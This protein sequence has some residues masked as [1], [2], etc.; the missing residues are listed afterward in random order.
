MPTPALS[1]HTQDLRP[2]PAPA[3]EPGRAGAGFANLLSLQLQAPS[4]A[5]PGLERHAE[6]PRPTV[7]RET[8]RR[9]PTPSASNA[10]STPATRP[11]EP[12]RAQERDTPRTEREP[13]T[14]LSPEPQRAAEPSAALRKPKTAAKPSGG[15]GAGAGDAKAGAPSGS[16]PPTAPATDTTASAAEGT[17]KPAAAE[18]EPAGADAASVQEAI[19]ALLAAPQ[20]ESA[21]ETTEDTAASPPEQASNPGQTQV[22]HSLAESVAPQVRPAEEQ[23]AEGPEAV[24]PAA[25]AATSVRAALH[26]AASPPVTGAPAAA[27]ESPPGAKPAAGDK[28]AP[29][30]ELPIKTERNGEQEA[31]PLELSNAT[32]ALTPATPDTPPT[33]PETPPLAHSAAAAVQPEASAAAAAAGLHHP[34]AAEAQA[35]R[36]EPGVQVLPPLAGSAPASGPALPLSGG[37]PV[38]SAYMR[39]APGQAGFAQELGAQVAVW[40]REGVQQAQLNLNPAELGPVQVRILLDGQQ[41]QVQFVVEH[42][43]TREA[44][45]AGVAE[46]NQALK[47]EGLSLGRA[48]VHTGSGRDSAQGAAAQGQDGRGDGRPRS[49]SPWAGEPSSPNTPQPR[50]PASRGLLDLYA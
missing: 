25:T 43:Q 2:Q 21:P 16:A 32:S 29:G 7:E 23:A 10:P 22:A 18:E 44:L 8:A 6:L 34:A 30:A 36:S 48:D 14:E 19:A 15:A 31:A 39:H 20:Q 17:A 40:V 26:A 1:L 47:S 37:S 12:A 13:S 28:M 42:S 24:R 38:G 49:A 41:A 27:E 11:S 46:L 5:P 3:A 9:T 33:P 50:K 45:Q 4:Q 35:P